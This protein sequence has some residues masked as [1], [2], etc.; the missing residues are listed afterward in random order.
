MGGL[1]LSQMDLNQIMMRFPNQNMI[2]NSIP[3][4]LNGLNMGMIGLGN[5]PNLV[6]QM[7]K[8]IINLFNEQ[9]KSYD[10]LPIN[11]EVSNEVS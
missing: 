5:N 10:V 9:V 4:G 8:P 2:F 3:V 11:R 6:Y 1:N 7:Q